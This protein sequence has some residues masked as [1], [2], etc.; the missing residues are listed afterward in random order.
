[1]A[2]FDEILRRR[3]GPM[4]DWMA[5]KRHRDPLPH[6][7]P[8]QLF[9]RRALGLEV[10]ARPEDTWAELEITAPALV[11]PE[12][13]SSKLDLRKA[14]FVAGATRW[15]SARDIE[16]R[17]RL[18][19][20][21]L[22]HLVERDLLY[23]ALEDPGIALT[24]EAAVLDG[25]PEGAPIARRR[26]AWPTP[27]IED[28]VQV[29]PMRFMPRGRDLAGAELVGF[30]LSSLERGLEVFG[31]NITGSRKTGAALR[32]IIPLLDGRRSSAEILDVFDATDR[33]RAQ[34]L[35]D[36][37]DR[38]AFLEPGE[39]APRIAAQ[40]SAPTLTWL[41]HA[42]V[43]IQAGG[44]NLLV[45]P[46]FFS[47]SEPE[48]PWASAPRFDPRS[49]PPLDAILITHGD[50]DHLNPNSLAQLPAHTRV[51]VPRCANPPPPY[52]V[53]IRSVLNVLGFTQVTPLGEWEP[54]DLGTVR[55]T[56]CPFRGEDWGL[57]LAQ[58]TYL[59]EAPGMTVFLS[60]DA[61]ELEGIAE[62]LR[63]RGPRVDFAFF[64][65]SGSAECMAMPAEFGYGNFYRDWIPA[66]EAARWMKHCAGPR[67]V[68][69]AARLL[70]P[71]FAMGYA[72][73]GA[74][75]IKTSFGDLGTHEQ[76]AALARES[77]LV[78]VPVALPIGVSRSLE[79]ISR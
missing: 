21:E 15:R 51:V 67:E 2:G 53:N 40:P 24:G 5:P 78:T 71:R 9:Y 28:A 37:L 23:Y 11:V 26:S 52:Q 70:E 17:D 47:A 12:A 34:K 8:E 31:A 18:S 54:L 39:R 77:G 32:A 50:N 20:S 36:L 79:E 44:K 48:E 29:A 4:R 41:G 76:F 27:A 73:G 72:A 7:E 55:I 69:A 57:E 1:M 74:S 38:L 49:L 65:V 62:E 14:G 58:A 68:V 75:Y 63:S 6:A 61:L 25:L 33:P 43:L 3:F 56:A 66:S 19:P 16:Q 46:L 22:W 42:G 45:D 64:G 59:V 35:L 13:R 30:R 60:A 10:R